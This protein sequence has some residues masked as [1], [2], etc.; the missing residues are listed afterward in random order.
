MARKLPLRQWQIT[1]VLW[2]YPALEASFSAQLRT[3]IGTKKG[4]ISMAASV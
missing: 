1:F 4:T 2:V 3:L